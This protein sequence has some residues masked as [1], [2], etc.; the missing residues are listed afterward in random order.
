[1]CIRD[2]FEALLLKPLFEHHFNVSYLFIF[3]FF[4]FSFLTSIAQWLIHAVFD[5]SLIW[6]DFMLPILLHLHDIPNINFCVKNLAWLIYIAVLPQPSVFP[7]TEHSTR[8]P[9]KIVLLPAIAARTYIIYFVGTTAT[10]LL[11]HVS[12]LSLHVWLTSVMNV[13]STSPIKVVTSNVTYSTASELDMSLISNNSVYLNLT[14]STPTIVATGL[15]LILY[16]PPSLIPVNLSVTVIIHHARAI[17]QRIADGGSHLFCSLP[18]L[19]R[20]V[21]RPFFSPPT[22]Y[23]CCTRNS[24]LHALIWPSCHQPSPMTFSTIFCTNSWSCFR[25]FVAYLLTSSYSISL[26]TNL[27]CIFKCR[28]DHDFVFFFSFLLPSSFSLLFSLLVVTLLITSLLLIIYLF[29]IFHVIPK[30]SYTTLLFI[31][32]FTPTYWPSSFTRIPFIV[33]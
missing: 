9:P 1:M 12:A 24:Y 28:A 11:S 21:Y 23:V 18:T 6:M 13:I 32:L 26:P 10:I 31:I 30:N 29:H 15:M 16:L 19:F 20:L 14:S 7:F 22:C 33:L 17:D 4:I 2:R 8:S 25:I 5:S 3:L 27:P